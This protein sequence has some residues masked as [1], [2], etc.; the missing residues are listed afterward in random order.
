[1]NFRRLFLTLTTVLAL[2]GLPLIASSHGYRLGDLAIRH[3]WAAP[4]Q[5][6]TGSGF[7]TLR[8]KSSQAD[9]LLSAAT[10]VA[11]KAELHLP[12]KSA[13]HQIKT[14]P[15]DAIAIPAGGETRLEPGGPHIQFNGLKKPLEE[16]ERFPVTL[17]FRNA[18]EITVEMWV[19]P[20]AK[21]SVY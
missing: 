21:H 12:I 6:S 18:G 4:T 5:T 7:L 1:L 20:T 10:T 16:G 9:T 2:F 19:Q 17:K 3:P 14:E 15:T 11:E 8:N 13:G